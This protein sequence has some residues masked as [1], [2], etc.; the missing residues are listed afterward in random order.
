LSGYRVVRPVRFW[1]LHTL[2]ITPIA[3]VALFAGGF[4]LIGALALLD[5]LVTGGE[6]TREG[7][8]T[9]GLYFL[10]AYAVGGPAIAIY[11]ALLLEWQRRRALGAIAAIACSLA[12][13]AIVALCLVAADQ[14]TAGAVLHGFGPIDQWPGAEIVVIAA[15]I[16]LWVFCT[17]TRFGVDAIAA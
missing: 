10:A 17:R 7:L 13:S 16:A 6:L 8:P 2:I 5:L 4:Q 3:A 9:I 12:T 14:L 11:V 1:V 15:F